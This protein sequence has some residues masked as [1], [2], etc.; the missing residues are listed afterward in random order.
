MANPISEPY[1]SGAVLQDIVP[2]YPLS[3][4]IKQKFMA[5]IVSEAL[6]YVGRELTRVSADRC[7]DGAVTSDVFLC[8]KRSAS[9]LDSGRYSKSKEAADVQRAVSH[10]A[11]S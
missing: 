1:Y 8:H 7:A 10:D 11:L 3:A 5:G 9:S 4:G 6:G 2:V